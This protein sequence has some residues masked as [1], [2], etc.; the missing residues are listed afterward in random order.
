MKTVVVMELLRGAPDYYLS[1]GVSSQRLLSIGRLFHWIANLI[2][3]AQV[4]A[5]FAV[6]LPADKVSQGGK[7]VPIPL[8][9][10]RIFSGVQL[11]VPPGVLLWVDILQLFKRFRN[12]NAEIRIRPSL[13]GYF[14]KVINEAVKLFSVAEDLLV[15]TI[16]VVAQQDFA[17]LG[18]GV[19][20]VDA[21]A[22][23]VVFVGHGF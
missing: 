4:K 20:L 6:S 17:V 15:L 21:F 5:G 11:A 18:A 14:L 19:V 16:G 8:V 9:T 2:L 13:V 7:C 23:V 1:Q 10:R 12:V 22:W 3:I